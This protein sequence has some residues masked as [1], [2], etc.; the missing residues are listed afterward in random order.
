[1]AETQTESKLRTITPELL[2]TFTE[3]VDID[4]NANAFNKPLPLPDGAY[5]AI[6]SLP[7]STGNFERT[8]LKGG[9]YKDKDGNTHQYFNGDFDVK[10]TDSADPNIPA[11]VLKGRPKSLRGRVNTF[12]RTDTKTGTETS[13]MATFVNAC[14]ARINGNVQ[15]GELGYAFLEALNAGAKVGVILQWQAGHMVGEKNKKTGKTYKTWEVV[16]SGMQNFPKNEDGSYNPAITV[17][18]EELTA[19]AEIVGFFPLQ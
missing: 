8:A 6:V 13:E 18:G 11:E 5:S 14:G 7:Q 12:N 15:L 1:M 3:K 9:E 17:N 16:R 2:A 4:A 19:R 10:I